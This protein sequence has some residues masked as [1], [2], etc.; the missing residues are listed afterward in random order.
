M[1]SRL[2]V[3]DEPRS[4][5][6]SS[7]TGPRTHSDGGKHTRAYSEFLTKEE[8]EA[9]SHRALRA[10]EPGRV[11]VVAPAQLDTP[12]ISFLKREQS[13]TSWTIGE[14]GPPI[15]ADDLGAH[16]FR[17]E[18]ATFLTRW[19]KRATALVNCG[20]AGARC[21]CGTC[22]TPHVLAY[23]CGARTCPTCAYIAAAVAGDKVSKRSAAAFEALGIDDLWEG[24]PINYKERSPSDASKPKRSRRRRSTDL[25]KPRRKSWRLV[26]LTT[27]TEGTTAEARYELVALRKR[28][29]LAR[30][31]LGA[32][33]RAT[34][35]GQRIN[36]VSAR[37]GRAT[38]RARRDTIY[39]AGLE[40]SPGGTKLPDGS[41]SL[42]GVVHVHLAVYG[43]FVSDW[44]LAQLWK[45]H[46]A[47]GGFI[48]VRT[49]KAKTAKDFRDAL[50]EVLKYVSKGD[51]APGSRAERA[52]AVECAFRNVRRV[53]MGG[54][55]RL[56]PSI[57]SKDVAVEGH[58][59]SACGE[60]SMWKWRGIRSPNYVRA[61]GGFGVSHI[62]DD[63]DVAVLSRAQTEAWMAAQQVIRERARADAHHSRPGGSFYGGT[64]PPWMDDPDE[65]ESTTVDR[66]YV[67]P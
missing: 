6:Y 62:V 23:R 32:W 18:V 65:W 3:P 53:E 30:T 19:P 11:V 63:A 28:A 51:K 57:T 56:V 12:R 5:R 10:L 37:T 42:G 43:E 31:A 60:A 21:D 49:I 13:G 40:I 58:V 64:A 55:I 35:W 54:A 66:E 33:W 41:L 50:A 16:Y 1:N 22:G 61:N 34:P 52:A 24:R 2:T 4:T 44:Y 67:R 29:K 45:E 15:Y 38:K 59:C 26:T 36:D 9:R 17:H 25:F 48:D 39:I 20:E 47:I 27:E 46:C 8:T 7:G 14:I